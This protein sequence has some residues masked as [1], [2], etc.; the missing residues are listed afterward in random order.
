MMS[1]PAWARVGHH[2]RTSKTSVRVG[3]GAVTIAV[4][5]N[6]DAR[7]AAAFLAELRELSEVC[8]GELV[9]DLTNCTEI[10]T[11]VLSGLEATH[12]A[13]RRA[14]C[15]LVV[16]VARP[17]IATALSRAGIPLV[18]PERPRSPEGR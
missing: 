4:T 13:C 15:R 3:D 6:L 8:V 17:D 12:D 14:R 5:S 10:T 7:N 11:A 2:L 1:T 18:D 9:V 16:R